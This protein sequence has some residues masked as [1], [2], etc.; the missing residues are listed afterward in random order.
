MMTTRRKP[1][2]KQRTSLTKQPATN[3]STRSD[4]LKNARLETNVLKSLLGKK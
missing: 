4:A 1:L 2:N 3:I